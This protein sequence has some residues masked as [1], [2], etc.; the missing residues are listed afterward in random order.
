MMVDDC[1]QCHQV[2]PSLHR[3]QHCPH[4]DCQ[5]DCCQLWPT[6]TVSNSDQFH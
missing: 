1:C 3:Q 5:F 6:A 2:F 4:L